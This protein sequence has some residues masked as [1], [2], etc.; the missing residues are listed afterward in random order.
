[1]SRTTERAPARILFSTMDSAWAGAQ[2]QMLELAAGLNREEFEPVVLTTMSGGGVLAEHSRDLGI[3]THVLPY[4]LLRREFPFVPHYLVGPMVLRTLLHRERVRLVHTHDPN[5]AQPIMRAA[6]GLGLPLVCHVHDFD[7]R[8]VTPRTLRL[9]NSARGTVVAISDAASRYL[10]ERGVNPSHVRRIY[11]G[12]HLVPLGSDARVRARRALGIA[13]GEIAVALV[14][15]FVERKGQDA[16]IRAMADAALANQPI[17]AFLIGC[18]EAPERAYERRLRALVAELGLTERIVFAGQRDDA[19]SLLA[20]IDISVVP[21]RREAFGRVVV[22]SLHAGAAVIVYRD[23]GLPEIVRDGRDGL[24]VSPDDV[25]ALAA[26]I[27]RLVSDDAL[28]RRLGVSAR[29][30]AQD[31]SHEHFVA[32]ITALYREL[33]SSPSDRTQIP[34]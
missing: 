17:R 25:V 18:A 26:A 15:R 29:T 27:A 7:Q 22:E 3:A 16:L 14:G 8:W 21:S 11:N 10:I 1:V 23:G 33:L 24:V 32:N 4:S 34:A 9:Q 31:F 28:R 19:T 20:G 5:S 6:L 12:V 2:A 13:E 30:R